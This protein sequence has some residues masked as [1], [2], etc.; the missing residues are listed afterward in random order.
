MKVE[1]GI[2]YIIGAMFPMQLILTSELSRGSNFWL[3]N[4]TN[5]LKKHREVH[6]LATEYEKHR[7]N[8]FTK[9]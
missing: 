3:R 9:R 4:L 5:Q 1:E 8:H 2:Y 6:D 7:N